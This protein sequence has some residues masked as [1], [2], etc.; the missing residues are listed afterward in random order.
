MNEAIVIPSEK[1]VAELPG[2]TVPERRHNI[3][4]WVKEFICMMKNP[5]TYY[6]VAGAGSWDFD[7]FID[8]SFSF[9]VLKKIPASHPMAAQLAAA[10]IIY[11][12]T[13]PQ[14][15]HYHFCKH[16]IGYGLY[17]TE[18]TAPAQFSRQVI[19]KRKA[20]AGANLTKR[21]HCLALE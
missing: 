15:M 10:C 18:Q 19:G 9:W 12:C 6:K 21:G 17:T 14:F 20:P 8:Y 5:A 4:Q 11:S 2:T 13:C 3:S 1:L 7:D 16:A